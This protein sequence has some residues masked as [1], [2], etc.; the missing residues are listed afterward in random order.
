VLPR[1]RERVIGGS[2]IEGVGDLDEVIC[3]AHAS[4]MLGHGHSPAQFLGG[5][6]SLQNAQ[7]TVVSFS[8]CS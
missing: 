8:G 1:E 2:G 6:Q 7:N 3:D 4:P 5:C